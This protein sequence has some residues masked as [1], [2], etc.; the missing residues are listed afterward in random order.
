[1][2]GWTRLDKTQNSSLSWSP[3]AAAWQYFSFEEQKVNTPFVEI[4]CRWRSEEKKR[5]GPYWLRKKKRL[6]HLNCCPV[7]WNNVCV[8]VTPSIFLPNPLIRAWM[9]FIAVSVN[10]DA[11]MP[12]TRTK[13]RSEGH[14]NSRSLSVPSLKVPALEPGPPS[15]RKPAAPF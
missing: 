1:M 13:L 5:S 7:H 2:A 3:L 11:V 12:H 9:L 14:H 4:R 15:F 10:T 6:N 8:T